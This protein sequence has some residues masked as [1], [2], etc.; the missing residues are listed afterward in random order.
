MVMYNLLCCSDDTWQ[1]CSQCT[2]DY[3]NSYRSPLCTQK[4]RHIGLLL[5]AQFYEFC[6][7]AFCSLCL[8]CR[9]SHTRR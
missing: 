8:S 2:N 7:C 6:V 4:G 5:T 1:Q 9:L 3:R